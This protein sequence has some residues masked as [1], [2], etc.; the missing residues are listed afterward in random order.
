[1]ESPPSAVVINSRL[2]PNVLLGEDSCVVDTRLVNGVSSALLGSPT[3]VAFGMALGLGVGTWGCVLDCEMLLLM[4]AG[5]DAGLGDSHSLARE[6]LYST[7]ILARLLLSSQVSV[8]PICH[9]LS[10]HVLIDVVVLGMR[11]NP[12]TL[13]GQACQVLAVLGTQDQVGTI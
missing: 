6:P 1:L 7:S 4:L 13:S 10:S 5:V 8:D 2:D 12:A 11:T 9:V 3:P